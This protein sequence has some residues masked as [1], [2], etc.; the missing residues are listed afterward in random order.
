M[1]ANTE[2]ILIF[3]LPI[4]ASELSAFETICSQMLE[5]VQERLVY[6]TYIF[7]RAEILNYKPAEGDLAYPEKLKMME[8]GGN[9]T[10]QKYV[11]IKIKT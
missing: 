1:I 9:M 4:S 7:I 2:Q 3:V 6:R 5:D 8:V 10:F 11:F